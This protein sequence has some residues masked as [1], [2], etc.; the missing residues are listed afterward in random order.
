[1]KSLLILGTS[2]ELIKNPIYLVLCLIDLLLSLAGLL[3]R[4]GELFILIE[5]ESEQTVI[6]GGDGV[7]AAGCRGV[8]IPGN[9]GHR[10]EG[11]AVE[12]R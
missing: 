1:M 7:V 2:A 8:V 6:V 3:H 11:F 5:E 10:S 9:V 4:K 12:E